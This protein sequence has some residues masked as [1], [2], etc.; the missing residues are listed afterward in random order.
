MDSG[1]LGPHARQTSKWDKSSKTNHQEWMNNYTKILSRAANKGC[2]TLD[3]VQHYKDNYDY[4]LPIWVAV[5]IMD[6]G[7]LRK[8]YTLLPLRLQSRISERFDLEAPQLGSWLGAPNHV[9][10]FAAHHA[11]MYNR[12][13]SFRPKLPNNDSTLKPTTM[14]LDMN[15]A[16][17]QFTLIQYMLKTLCLSPAIQIPRVFETY[18]DNPIIPIERTGAPKNW[19]DHPLWVHDDFTYMAL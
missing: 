10:N 2:A 13:Y 9:R 8:L 16:F 14:R 6:W 19:R 7:M 3:F 1:K 4:Q 5:E 15:R 11:R 17:G 12:N 18:P